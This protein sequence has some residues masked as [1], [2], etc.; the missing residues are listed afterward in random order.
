MKTKGVRIAELLLLVQRHYEVNKLR[1]SYQVNLY[2]KNQLGP[3]LGERVANNMRKSH[4][5]EYKAHRKREG[6]SEC[7]INRELQVLSKA[8]TLGLEDEIIERK[9]PI[10]LFPEPEPREGHY[11]PEEYAKWQE[12]CRQLKNGEVIADVVMFAYHSGWRLGECLNLH[13]D[14]VRLRDKIAVLPKQFSKNK[15]IRIYPL[16]GKVLA[17]VEQ[18]LANCNA[19]GLLFHRKGKRIKDLSVIC[20]KVCALVG[21]DSKHFFHNLRRSC[22]TNLNRAGV[23]NETGKRITGH[24]TDGIYHNYNQHTVESIR[25]AVKRVEEYLE[26]T[27]VEK[28]AGDVSENHKEVQQVTEKEEQKAPLVLPENSMGQYQDGGSKPIETQ[29]FLARLWRLFTKTG[30]N[31]DAGTK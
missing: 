22:T 21:L 31:S 29:G 28:Q 15:R 19:D 2:I 3:K 8:F 23:D 30:D 1:S 9:P 24:L 14:W 25:L 17:M 18:R 10:K 11:E 27:V 13:R 12:A 4:I 16:E 7:T 26:T 6:A 5:E 20:K